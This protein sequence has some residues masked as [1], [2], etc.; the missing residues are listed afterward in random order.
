MRCLLH[1][2]CPLRMLFQETLHM[3]ELALTSILWATQQLFVHL[4]CA[5]TVQAYRLQQ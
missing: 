4:L 5:S 3:T 2:L 1:V